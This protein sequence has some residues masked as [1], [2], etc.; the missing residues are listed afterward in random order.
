MQ[1]KDDD[2]FYHRWSTDF[3]KKIATIRSSETNIVAID[4][5]KNFSKILRNSFCVDNIDV[6]QQHFLKKRRYGWKTV[7]LGMGNER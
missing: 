2:S 4:N 6:G 1:Y 7:W 3:G 5:I